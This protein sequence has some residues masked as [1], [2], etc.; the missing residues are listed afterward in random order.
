MNDRGYQ[1]DLMTATGRWT[2]AQDKRQTKALS[3]LDH[4]VFLAWETNPLHRDDLECDMHVVLKMAKR[5]W[6]WRRC[7][8]KSG[9]Q[10]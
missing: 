10:S 8:C 2:A 3:G 7:R 5:T 4:H 9:R 6:P 1:S